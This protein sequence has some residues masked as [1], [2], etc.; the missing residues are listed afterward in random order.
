MKS[1]KIKVLM[2]TIML[3]SGVS[4]A[5]GK[6]IRATEMGSSLWFDLSQGKLNN[7]TV[8]FRQGDEL[9][10]SLEAQG[11]LMETRQTSVSYVTIKKN[12][13]IRLSQSQIEISF[14]GI[15]FKKFNEA[16]KGSLD[17]GTGS[18]SNGGAANSINIIF[19]AFLK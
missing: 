10:V 19:K 17:V 4:Q 6:I 16:L 12:F 1:N 2:L 7:V 5:S 9:P 8:E 3:M 18:E 13:W 14:D 11:D 15:T